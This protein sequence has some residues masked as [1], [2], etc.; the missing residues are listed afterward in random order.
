MIGRDDIR[1][2]VII[3]G[4][5]F[6]MIVYIHACSTSRWLATIWQLSWWGATGEV[7]VEFK[8]QRCSCKLSFLFLPRR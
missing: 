1:N 4:M 3:L 7:E 5:Y 6:S 2:Y 8:F